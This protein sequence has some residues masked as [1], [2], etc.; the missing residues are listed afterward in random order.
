MLLRFKKKCRAP[1]SICLWYHAVLI[2]GP[3]VTWKKDKTDAHGWRKSPIWQLWWRQP[4]KY[5]SSTTTY[6]NKD[7][8]LLCIQVLKIEWVEPAADM[9]GN[10]EIDFWV[11]YED[12]WRIFKDVCRF[13]NEFWRNWF[14]VRRLRPSINRRP[15]KK[16]RLFVVR[17]LST[18]I[19][20]N[21]F[22]F[23][24]FYSTLLWED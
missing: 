8:V 6:W 11:N 9:E 23:G 20:K 1:E 13:L 24:P 12:F 7:S 21:L 19:A 15:T 14:I 16:M 4:K 5:H 10:G 17:R 2:Y 3:D 22:S 18:S